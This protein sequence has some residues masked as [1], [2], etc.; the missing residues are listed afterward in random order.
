M[1]AA[2]RSLGLQRLEVAVE[3]GDALLDL[4]LVE[5]DQEHF[6]F[7]SEKV[8]VKYDRLRRAVCLTFAM[9]RVS[10]EHGVRL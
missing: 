9:R 1:T 10:E 2:T 3:V 7:L 8:Q 5:G 4:G 6:R